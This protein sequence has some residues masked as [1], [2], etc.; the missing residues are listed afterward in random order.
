M[1]NIA[2]KTKGGADMARPIAPTPALRGKD[3]ERF[4]AAANSPM[5]FPPPKVNNKNELDAIK[6]RLIEREQKPVQ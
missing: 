2:Y 4:V 5:P 1:A 3:A 6:Q